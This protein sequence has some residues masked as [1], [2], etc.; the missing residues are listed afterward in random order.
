MNNEDK[1]NLKI[2]A[3]EEVHYERLKELDNQVANLRVALTEVSQTL[4]ATEQEFETYKQMHPEETDVPQAPEDD[5][6]N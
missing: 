3:I 1:L 2:Q 6:Q 4:Q 5:T